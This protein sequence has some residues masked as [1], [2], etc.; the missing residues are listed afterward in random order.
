MFNVKFG[1]YGLQGITYHVLHMVDEN[2]VFFFFFCSG[3]YPKNVKSWKSWKITLFF[4][5]PLSKVSQ[6]TGNCLKRLC[7]LSYSKRLTCDSIQHVVVQFRGSTTWTF[8]SPHWT[9]KFNLN[10]TKNIVRK[11]LKPCLNAVIARHTVLATSVRRYLEQEPGERFKNILSELFLRIFHFF[12]KLLKFGILRNF[13]I[14]LMEDRINVVQTH[15][16]KI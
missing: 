1:M 5:F 3:G 13:C 14:I 12:R 15:S 9:K 16:N 8:W 11:H 2:Q 10:F 4:I 6:C 7:S